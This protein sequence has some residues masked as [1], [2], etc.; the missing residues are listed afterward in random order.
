MFQRALSLLYVGTSF[1]LSLFILVQIARKDDI[2]ALFGA[3]V[4]TLYIGVLFASGRVRT[5]ARKAPSVPPRPQVP[6]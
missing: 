3:V 1:G 4:L 5:R 2:G 6:A